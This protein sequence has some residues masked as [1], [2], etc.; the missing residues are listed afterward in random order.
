[1]WTFIKTYAITHFKS[2][3]V[4]SILV[5]IIV[6]LAI[7]LHY[8][9]NTIISKVTP[10]YKNITTV[11]TLPNT[12]YKY[13][14]LT[15]TKIRYIPTDVYKKITNTKTI[16]QVFKNSYI[17]ATGNVPPYGGETN[18]TCALNKNT[19]NGKL[20]F[21]QLPYIPKKISKPFFSVKP[22][23]MVGVGYGLWMG[24]PA[25]K[26]SG[27]YRFI[28]IYKIN[29]SAH[30]DLYTG[31]NASNWLGIQASATFR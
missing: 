12:Q 23:Y 8:A 9:N 24:T 22:R 18:V 31:I 21:K 27:D 4:I 30:D 10:T 5:A 14:Y 26:I 7:R 2:L 17:L 1:M 3:F 28:R 20:Y 11:P 6:T 19:G 25:V 13:I 16:P 29:I 15:K